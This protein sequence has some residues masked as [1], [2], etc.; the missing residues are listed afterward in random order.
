MRKKTPKELVAPEP[1]AARQGGPLRR[2]AVLISEADVQAM[3]A[4][5]AEGRTASITAHAPA[6]SK[7]TDAQREY[8]KDYRQR[9]E[10]RAKQKAYRALRAKRVREA[11][12]RDAKVLEGTWP[13]QIGAE[14]I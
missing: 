1:A 11:K 9:P 2:V 4:S 8:R 7:L 5:F 12:S 10:V 3:Q 13:Q 6:A 14:G